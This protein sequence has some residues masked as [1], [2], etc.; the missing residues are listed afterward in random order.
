[1]YSSCETLAFRF[2]LPGSSLD[3]PSNTPR[4][5]QCPPIVFA[6]PRR[7]PRGPIPFR[8]SHNKLDSRVPNR[9]VTPTILKIRQGR[10]NVRRLSSLVPAAHQED[11]FL[12]DYRI[13]NSIAGSPID[14]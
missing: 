11:Q 12:S 2:I 1:M 8:L 4:P 7:S 9:C 14:A 6:C 13:I 5:T 3:N 10:L